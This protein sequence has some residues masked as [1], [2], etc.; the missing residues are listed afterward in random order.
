MKEPGKG[1]LVQCW[2]GVAGTLTINFV[3]DFAGQ[4]Q[5]RIKP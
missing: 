5:K 4:V 2:V 3:S 1:R